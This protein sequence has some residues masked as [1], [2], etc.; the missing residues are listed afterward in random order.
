MG[1]DHAE[2]YTV[3]GIYEDNFQ[4]WAEYIVASSGEEARDRVP[5]GIVVAGVVRGAHECVA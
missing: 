3:F 5:E 2:T 4:P 1:Y